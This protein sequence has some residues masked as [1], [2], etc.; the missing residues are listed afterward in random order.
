MA[1]WLQLAKNE[2]TY[3]DF[4]VLAEHIDDPVRLHGGRLFHVD[5]VSVERL[6]FSKFCAVQIIQ[7]IET[8]AAV[9]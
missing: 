1:G 2:S 7:M 4:V 8:G 9:N 5:A 6:H 3:F